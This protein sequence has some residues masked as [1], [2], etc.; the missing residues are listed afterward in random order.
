MT[1]SEKHCD[2]WSVLLGDDE[3]F[4][5]VQLPAH[6][7][8][9]Q[10]ISLLQQVFFYSFELSPVTLSCQCTSFIAVCLTDS[11]IGILA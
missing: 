1:P 11:L 9:Q 8:D 5:D 4:A 2:W 6:I 7:T 3:L 10:F